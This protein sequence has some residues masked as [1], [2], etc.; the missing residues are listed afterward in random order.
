MWTLLINPV[1][2][3]QQQDVRETSQ[4]EREQQREQH[5]KDKPQERQRQRPRQHQLTTTEI[6]TVILSQVS[7][8]MM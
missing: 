7:N 2:L 8:L 5:Q 1:P 6:S 3:Y 4:P